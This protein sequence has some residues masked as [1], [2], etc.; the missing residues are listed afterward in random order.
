M[1][2]STVG[3]RLR[4]LDHLVDLLLILGEVDARTGIVQQVLH[5]CHGIGRIHARGD[6]TDCDGCEVER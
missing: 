5:L 6:G 2:F 3:M 1:I 4:G